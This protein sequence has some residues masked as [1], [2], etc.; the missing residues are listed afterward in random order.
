MRY[1]STFS[2]I[3]ICLSI[4]S[5]SIFSAVELSDSQKQLLQTLPPDQQKGVMSKMLQADQLNTELQDTFEEF[6]TTTERAKKKELSSEDLKRYRERSKNWVYGYEVFQSSPTTFA[7][8]TDIPISGDY[9]L[10][11]GDEIKLQ[12]FGNRNF[13]SNSFITRNGDITIP[14]IG[15]VNVAGLNLNK[16]IDLINKKVDSKLI[17]S[18][19]YV[20]LG[21]LRT[22]TVFVL[23]EAYQPGSY[24]IS[25]FSTLTNLLFV[26]GGVSEIG[27][28]RN[29]QLKRGGK[30]ISTFDLYDVL[31]KGDTS[32]DVLLKQGDTIFIPLI[33][34]KA[35]VYGSFRR[36]DLFELKKGDTIKDLISYAGGL[37]NQVKIDGKLELTRFTKDS[38]KVRQLDV[39]DPSWLSQAVIDG[40]TLSAQA[41]SSLSQGVV[42]LT[43]QVRYPGFYQ[44]KRK[45]K[46]SSVIKRA[47]GYTDSAYTHGAVYTREPVADQQKLSY[48]RSADYLEQSIADAIT[49]GG[50]ENL[51][52]QSFEPISTLITRLR[53][54]EAS[55]RQVI[56]ADPLKIKSDP[57][58]DFSLQNGDTL[59]IPIRPNE[60]TVVGEV[61]NPSS[62]TF[63]PGKSVEDYIENAGGFKKTA[64][65][66]NV[67]IILPNGES[68]SYNEKKFWG[69][70]IYAIPGTTI[71]IPRSSFNWL[72]WTKTITPILGDSA[73]A[74]ATVVALLDND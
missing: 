5:L 6:D 10:G 64:D 62:L 22:I 7:P 59:H 47:G 27:S 36:P 66:K 68:Q 50:I 53:Q 32:K 57:A 74:L 31:L 72:V 41:D 70:E 45:E 73:T 56:V 17:G 3:P 4:M 61:I 15:P 20:S 39:N 46:L 11:P 69:D 1:F 51:S 16:A 54:L 9:I 2:L 30:T 19:A 67:F 60:I 29:I 33:E 65:R 44:I 14:E 55:G 37:E 40:D 58:L 8:A 43:G 49:G 21:K 52:V 18:E 26:T 34:S 23:G 42:E 28:V 71:V 24:K 48:E 35:S 12:I 25:S 38:I 13:Q 63:R